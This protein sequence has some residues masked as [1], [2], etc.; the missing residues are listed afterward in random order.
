MPRLRFLH[1][2]ILV[3][4][5]ILSTQESPYTGTIKKI[6]SDKGT[7][8]I[9]SLGQT[10]QIAVTDQSRFRDGAGEEIGRGLKDER[11]KEGVSVMFLTA[12]QDG[13]KVL[14]GMRLRSDAEQQS[15]IQRGRIAKL[16]L[17][18]MTITI[19]VRGKDVELGLIEKTRVL[20]A[21]G[22]NLHERLR[23]FREGSGVF[24]QTT[25]SENKPIARALKL[26][27]GAPQGENRRN[28]SVDTSKFKPLAELGVAEYSGFQ[29]GLYPNGKNERPAAHEA[30][31]QDLARSVQPLDATGKAD[32]AGQIV[33]LSIGM[34]NATQEFSAFKRIAD[35]DRAKSSKVV[36]VDGAQGG[37][38][39]AVI[40]NPEDNGRGTQYWR[41]V[42]ER[43]AA[44]GASREQVQAVWIKE[45][46]AGPTQGF[47]K[48][49]QILQQELG[50]IVRLL[51][52]RFPNLKLAYLSCRT[53]GGYARTGLNPEPYAYESGFSVKWLIE[54]QI[55]GEPPLNFDPSRGGVMAPW[56]SWGPYLWA[57]GTRA[58]ADGLEYEENDFGNDGTHPSESGRRKVAQLLLR[59]F[60]ADSTTRDWF[61]SESPK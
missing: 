11:I 45:A 7:I 61:L 14:I 2:F 33:L 18:R 12:E 44:A 32:A 17:E 21:T 48:Y 55:R 37:M 24:F 34:S 40:R 10:H 19:A 49:A 46:D 31:G 53:Y 25:L 42:D 43:L 59:F 23:D 35:G 38:T 9:E 36:I 13:N 4:A 41:V 52:D 6:D 56:L 15:E 50:D 29:G 30:A 28:T 54:Q 47:P 1:Q 57:N 39:A 26:A 60:K 22:K 8:T 5:C 27:D 58:N 20:G 3:H 51:H 16:D